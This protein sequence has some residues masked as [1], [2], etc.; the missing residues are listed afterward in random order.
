MLTIPIGSYF[1][2]QKYLFSELKGGGGGEIYSA[3][4]A[5]IAANLLL[6]AYVFVA[7][8]EDQEHQKSSSFNSTHLVKTD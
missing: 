4:I 7:I 2:A 3:I 1:A 6:V 5:V 8:Q